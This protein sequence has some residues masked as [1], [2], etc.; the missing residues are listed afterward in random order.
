M[1]NKAT[2]QAVKSVISDSEK[3]L[4]GGF[5]SINIFDPNLTELALDLF[6]SRTNKSTLSV[7][8]S[9]A[10]YCIGDGV[11]SEFLS[12]DDVIENLSENDIKVLKLIEGNYHYLELTLP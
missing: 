2:K 7:D 3:L 9:I 8:E 12:D 1:K 11:I 6:T 4:L 5:E 10:S